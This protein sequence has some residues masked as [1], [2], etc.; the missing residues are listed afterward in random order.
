MFIGQGGVSSDGNLTATFETVQEGSFRRHRG[1]S[2]LIIES[3]QD[4]PHEII[5]GSP[6]DTERPLAYRR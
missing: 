6:F 2:G 3:R 5:V 4:G 1:L